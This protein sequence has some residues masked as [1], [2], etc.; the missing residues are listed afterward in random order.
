MKFIKKILVISLTFLALAFFGQP[1]F[2]AEKINI[3]TA[4][5]EQLQELP[6]IGAVMA[7]RI[8][9]YRENKPFETVDE[10]TEVSGIG[11]TTLEKLRHLVTVDD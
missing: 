2:S 8:V 4:S 7:E 1:A 6:G 10:M 11:A 9:E 5:V 3:N